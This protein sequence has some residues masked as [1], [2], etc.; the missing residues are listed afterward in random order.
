ML[1]RC[2]Y[3]KYQEEN[4]TY[5]DCTVIE[6]W[7]DFQVFA[8]WYENHEY[9]NINYHL[10]KDILYTN[11]KTYSPDTCCFVPAELNN[12]LL[13]NS[14]TKGKY[15]QGVCFHKT[16]GKYLAQLMVDGRSKHLGRFTC[17]NEAHLVYKKAKEAHVKT[18]ALEWQDGIA[19]DV[20]DALMSWELSL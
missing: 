3:S 16:N 9:R 4:P 13:S 17:P 11:N 19:R 6:Q 8:E 5:A 15:P 1:R 12:L 2:Y 20:F 14:S 7:H 10:D 18:K